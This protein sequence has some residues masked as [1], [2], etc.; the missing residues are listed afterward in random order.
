MAS[1]NR[2][3]SVA[4]SAAARYGSQIAQASTVPFSNAARASAG[5]RNTTFTS[6]Y[7]T[8]A[9]SNARTKK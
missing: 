5:G 3:A 8:A 6:A 1:V 9:A 2:R 4:T 7:G